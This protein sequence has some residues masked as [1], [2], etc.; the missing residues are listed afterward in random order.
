[1]WNCFVPYSHFKSEL[2]RLNAPKKYERFAANC[3]HT[4]LKLSLKRKV[5]VR[6]RKEMTDQCESLKV[7]K[8]GL[9]SFLILKYK[10]V[11]ETLTVPE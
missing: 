3:F 4:Q 5:V 1:M 2:L 9:Y 8:A 6:G 7:F 11:L 10:V